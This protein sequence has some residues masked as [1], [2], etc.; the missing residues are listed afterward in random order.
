MAVPP[1]AGTSA[2]TERPEAVELLALLVARLGIGVI[3][4]DLLDG[5]VRILE[6]LASNVELGNAEVVVTTEANGQR[7]FNVLLAEESTFVWV[8]IPVR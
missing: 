7:I 3:A 6:V 2:P 1:K 8:T 4:V 5:K